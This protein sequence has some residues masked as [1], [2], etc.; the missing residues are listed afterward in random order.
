MVFDASS[1]GARGEKQEANRWV[2]WRLVWVLLMCFF[3]YK[4]NGNGMSI[5]TP[6]TNN[7]NANVQFGII[8][9][10]LS[11]LLLWGAVGLVWSPSIYNLDSITKRCTLLEDLTSEF[12]KLRLRWVAT[13]WRHG[14]VCYVFWHTTRFFCFYYGDCHIAIQSEEKYSS[15]LKAESTNLS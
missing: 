5:Q 2:N 6:P 10:F 8:L 4:T 13:R 9:K 1:H 14:G 12:W 3:C 15:T 7:S 11:W